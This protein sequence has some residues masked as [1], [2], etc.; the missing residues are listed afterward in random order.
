MPYE[1]RK[2]T[3][4]ERAAVVFERHSRGFPLHSPPHLF[5]EEGYYLLTAAIYEHLPLLAASSRCSAFE[6][7]LLESLAAAEITVFSWAVLPNHYHLLV[8]ARD[9]ESISRTLNL[10]HG[11][12]SRQ[13]NL[14]DGMTGKRKVW[15]SFYDQAIRNERH[16]ET[17]INYIHYNPVKHGWTDDPYE[18]PWSSLE[19]YLDSIG[20]EGLREQWK[21]FPPGRFGEGWDD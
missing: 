13:W 17:A 20:R 2:L 9:F 15:Y 11:R 14:E 6:A 3:P 19:N 12:S 18:W 7:Q 8:Y 4:E 21:R 5:R 10:I 16:F 1:Y